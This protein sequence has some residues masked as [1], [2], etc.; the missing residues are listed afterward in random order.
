MR[1]RDRGPSGPPE[2]QWAIEETFSGLDLTACHLS[3]SY[4]RK[5]RSPAL[6]VLAVYIRVYLRACLFKAY[7]SSLVDSPGHIYL[8]M[9]KICI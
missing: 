2:T 1:H 8:F 3:H 7:L 6:H 4:A 5:S 9:Y